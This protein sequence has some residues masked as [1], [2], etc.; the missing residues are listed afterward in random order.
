MR[1]FP[2]LVHAALLLSGCGALTKQELKPVPKTLTHGRFVYLADRVCRRDIR[3][4]KRAL[5]TPPESQAESYR[6][7]LAAYN[8]QDLLLH[9]LVQAGD[10]GRITKAKAVLKKLEIN[11]VSLKS[12]AYDLGL[13]TCAK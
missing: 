12:R 11:G 13:K 3:R 6:R 9:N 10:S 5:R 4:V 1:R 2:G 8:Y 7:L